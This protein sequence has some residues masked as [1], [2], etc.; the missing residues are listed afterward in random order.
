MKSHSNQYKDNKSYDLIHLPLVSVVVVSYNSAS[1]ILETLDS[2]KAQTYKN[3]ELIV[4]DDCSTDKKTIEIIQKWLDAYGSEFIHAE[5]ITTDKNTGVSGNVNRGIAKSRGEWIKGIAGDDLLIP[6][7][8]EEYVNFIINHSEKVRMCVCDV[9]PF[10]VDG[11]V[12]EA[13]IHSYARFLEKEFE[14]Y[15][16][17]RKR[18]MTEL[19]FVGPGYFY[20]RELYDEIGGFSD[21]YGNAEEWPFVYKIIMGGNRIYV[22]DKKLVRYRVQTS[23]LCH[24]RD[25][26]NLPN[27]SVFVGMYNHYFDH[28]FGDLIR[29][30]RLLTAWHYALSYW[31]RRMQ[32]H[33]SNRHLRKVVVLGAHVLSPLAYFMTIKRISVLFKTRC[34]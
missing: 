23:S 15:E 2:I 13:I 19:V 33:I 21:K 7:A 4:S 6:T 34:S 26:K 27:K 22:L 32:Y 18:V 20:S 17:Q 9:E 11:E 10:S 24:I 25:D 12:P 30:G 31:G 29:D 16:L 14:P 28:A 5:L 8:I 3:L 1:T